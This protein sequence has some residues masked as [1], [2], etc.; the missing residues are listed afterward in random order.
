MKELHLTVDDEV[1]NIINNKK[2]LNKYSYSKAVNDLVSVANDYD[3]LIQE[4]ENVK[5]RMD[6][7][8]A[9][10]Y[11]IIDLLKQLYSDMQI[12]NLTE[13]KKNDALQKFF[14]LRRKGHND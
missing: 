3:N 5:K 12:V 9:K 7:I 2:V 6:D 13:P 11:L 8:F 14:E 10:E 1:F 4:L